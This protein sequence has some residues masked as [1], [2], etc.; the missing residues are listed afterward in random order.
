[1]R[2]RGSARG[3]RIVS[4]TIYQGE[5]SVQCCNSWHGSASMSRLN[6]I[7]TLYQLS[8]LQTITP[9]VPGALYFL[10]LM[11]ARTK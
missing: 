3:L 5:G 9:D 4:F 11:L 7:L 1:M 2:K 6:V 10:K 8:A